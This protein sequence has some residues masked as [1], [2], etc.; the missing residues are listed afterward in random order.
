MTLRA[1]AKLPWMIRP[2]EEQLMI[3]AGPHV[4]YFDLPSDSFHGSGNEPRIPRTA[5]IAAIGYEASTRL[6]L[7]WKVS[8]GVAAIA[9]LGEQIVLEV[10]HKE[11]GYEI[12]FIRSP[13][14]TTPC[15][16]AM[17]GVN[18]LRLAEAKS[19]VRRRRK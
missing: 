8:D 9:R 3:S 10:T 14:L 7:E 6:G 17:H 12:L 15:L 5:A 16:A 2:L 4:S 19:T 13:A 1:L 11:K 18:L